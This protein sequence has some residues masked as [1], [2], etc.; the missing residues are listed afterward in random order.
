MTDLELTL[1]CAE[2]MGVSKSLV[3]EGG[4]L[5]YWP[6]HDD[7]QAM[8]LVKKFRLSVDIGEDCCDAIWFDPEDIEDVIRCERDDE[9]INAA[10]VECVAKLHLARSKA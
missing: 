9:N 1:L 10:I 8:A 7:A 3:H 6:L 4:A 5:R 2:A